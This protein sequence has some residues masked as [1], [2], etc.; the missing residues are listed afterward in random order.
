MEP[1]IHLEFRISKYRKWDSIIHDQAKTFLNQHSVYPNLMIGALASFDKIDRA[2]NHYPTDE[3]VAPTEELGEDDQHGPVC[4]A[5]A[6]PLGALGVF[7][8]ARRRR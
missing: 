4:G 2:V 1:V 6:L 7:L 8:V 5:M 3:P